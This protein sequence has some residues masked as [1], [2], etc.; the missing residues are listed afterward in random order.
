VQ[1]DVAQARRK[2]LT[3][4]AIVIVATVAL[5]AVGWLWT[6]L[7]IVIIVFDVAA[8]AFTLWAMNKAAAAQ[9]D[10]GPSSQP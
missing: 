4:T 9:R 3:S 8:A 6:W 10:G 2:L 5:A 1:Q 7:A